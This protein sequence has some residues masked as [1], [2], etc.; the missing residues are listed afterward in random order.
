MD[1]LFLMMLLFIYTIVFIVAV[2][3]VSLGWISIEDNRFLNYIFKNLD[4]GCKKF[5]PT[6]VK[7]W[8]EKAKI[9]IFYERNPLFQLLYATL[10]FFGYAAYTKTAFK[11]VSE[12]LMGR[13]PYYLLIIHLILFVACCCSDPG[14][15][16]RQTVSK[17]LKDYKY[18]GCMY[19]PKDCQT[20]HLKKPARSKHCS[21]CNLCIARFDHH[22]SF[23]NVCIGRNNHRYF[24]AFLLSL[25]L[26]CGVSS[27]MIIMVFIHIV[28]VNELHV[29]NFVDKYGQVHSASL[30]TVIQQ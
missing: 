15:V 11:Y 28:N 1:A 7:K 26:M 14:I 3:F 12:S 22:C 23:L 21:L 8:T 30:R 6:A 5:I 17:Y 24:A 16:T 27:F 4:A 19:A 29:A 2:V 10:L 13:V 20:C 25:V 18:D 9:F